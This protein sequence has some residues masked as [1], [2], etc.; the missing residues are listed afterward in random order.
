MSKKVVLITGATSGIGK[1]SLVRLIADGHTVCGSYRKPED[2]ESIKEAGGHPV[3][4]DVTDHDSLEK[5]VAAVIEEQGRIDVLF[6]NAGYGVYG[7]VEDVSIDDARRQFEVN[8]FGLARITQ[9][10]LPHMRKQ[11]SGLILN[12]SSVGGQ[13]HMPMG[14]WYH[15]SKFALEG[16][17]DCLRLELKQFNIDVVLIEP[18]LIQTNFVDEVFP[19]L[20]EIAKEG[21]YEKMASGFMA[22]LEKAKGEASPPSVIADVVAD[23]VQAAKPRTRYAAGAM[24]KPILF[25]RKYFGDRFFDWMVMNRFGSK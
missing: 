21:P 20:K 8:L 7:A 15:A 9:L 14:A 22:A 6:N 1:A 16:W 24:A 2:A 17:S 18:G 13:I 5:G 3:A 11:R 10:V 23:A 25:I 12:A 19:K 4:M